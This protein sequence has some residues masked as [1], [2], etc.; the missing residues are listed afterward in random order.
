MSDSSDDIFEDVPGAGEPE[1][2]PEVQEEAEPAQAAWWVDVVA[3]IIAGEKVAAG[4]AALATQEK[5]QHFAREE[6]LAAEA[7]ATVRAD[8]ETAADQALLKALA[9]RDQ[10]LAELR[11]EVQ[12]IKDKKDDPEP[13]HREF[14]CTSQQHFFN[15]FN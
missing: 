15:H 5:A 2:P 14:V 13:E 1:A 8:K 11:Q 9:S 6:R 3:K 10:Q 12:A 7:A 4:L